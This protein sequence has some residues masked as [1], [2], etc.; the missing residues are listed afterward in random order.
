M[1]KGSGFRLD[2]APFNRNI[3]NIQ[4]VFK[5]AAREGLADAGEELM[6]DTILDIPSTPILTSA[7]RG[8]GSVYVSG[9]KTAD[10]KRG[11]PIYRPGPG[12]SGRKLSDMVASVVFNAPY[13]WIQHERYPNKKEPSAGMKYLQKKLYRNAKGYFRIIA[14]TINKAMKGYRPRA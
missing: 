9:R 1:P 2:I 4:Q 7:L 14:F 6:D 8:S 5:A 13:A 10:S 3:E 12:A 11:I